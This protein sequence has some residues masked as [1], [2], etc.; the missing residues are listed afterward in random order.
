VDSKGGCGTEMM[1]EYD[2]VLG[3]TSGYPT[4]EFM[5]KGWFRLSVGWALL[6]LD[7]DEPAMY[8]DYYFSEDEWFICLD[9]PYCPAYIFK[10]EKIVFTFPWY[11]YYEEYHPLEEKT[12]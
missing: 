2:P 11:P 7:E 9:Q 6:G 4:L 5:K 10:D 8:F 12:T 3:D 1:C